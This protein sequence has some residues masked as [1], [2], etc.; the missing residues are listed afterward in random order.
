M[1]SFKTSLNEFNTLL[2]EGKTLEA[3]ERF[4]ADNILVQENDDPP[5]QG[6]AKSLAHERKNLARF[7]SLKIELLNQAVDEDR[8][9]VFTEMDLYF[10]TLDDV[11]LHLREVSV[12]HWADDA[13]IKERFYYKN[14]RPLAT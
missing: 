2:R 1:S 7:K 3:M 9:V 11:R 13:I 5:R 8:Q 14:I 6:K 4:H 10:T 12:Q